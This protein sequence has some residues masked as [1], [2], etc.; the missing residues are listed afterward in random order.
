VTRN[1]Q[2]LLDQLAALHVPPGREALRA[3]DLLQKAIAASI[4]V[5]GVY[6]DW[7]REHPKCPHGPPPRA[8]SAADARATALK[9]R[10]LAA[11]NPLAKRF[12]KRTWKAAEF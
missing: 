6:R 12:G 3:S 8:L 2:S 10:F 7:L 4:A 5:D 9:L 1:R 11:F